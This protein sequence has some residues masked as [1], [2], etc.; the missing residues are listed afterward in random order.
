MHSRLVQL[1]YLQETLA[2]L[3]FEGKLRAG[4]MV[5]AGREK[6]GASYLHCYQFM[7][8]VHRRL[9]S[10]SNHLLMTSTAPR[11]ESLICALP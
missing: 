5:P 9:R 3:I 11:D 4:T 8:L 6:V 7:D 10:L 2:L 1:Q